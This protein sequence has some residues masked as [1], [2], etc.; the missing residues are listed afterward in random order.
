MKHRQTW[1]PSCERPVT[2]TD[3]RRCPTCDENLKDIDPR[4]WS[5]IY[6]REPRKPRKQKGQEALAL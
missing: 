5:G 3:A 4:D 2:P 6:E 1:C